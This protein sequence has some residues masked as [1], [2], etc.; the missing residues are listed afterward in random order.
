ML[1]KRMV[2]SLV[3]CFISYV[4]ADYDDEE[5]SKYFLMYLRKN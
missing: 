1:S 4:A 5:N 2:F 3:Y